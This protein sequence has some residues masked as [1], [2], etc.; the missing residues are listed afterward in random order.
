MNMVSR[1]H[2]PKERRTTE[3][4]YNLF[5][6]INCGNNTTKASLKPINHLNETRLHEFAT[7]AV[8]IEII[9]YA[10]CICL[11]SRETSVLLRD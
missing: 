6:F 3:P 5:H 1:I 8:K 10:L 11:F 2:I 4:H 9:S 7:H